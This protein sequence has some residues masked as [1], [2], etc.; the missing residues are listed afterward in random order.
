M[1]ACLPCPRTYPDDSDFCPRDGTLCCS[2]DLEVGTCRAQA[3]RYVCSGGLRPP[4]GD[5][6]SPLQS[7]GNRRAEGLPL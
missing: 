6:R 4:S 5:R 1:R 2:A 7:I 3:R